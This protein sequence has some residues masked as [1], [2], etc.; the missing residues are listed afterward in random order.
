MYFL[1]STLPFYY[2]TN[3]TIFHATCIEF[4][5]WIYI[6]VRLGSTFWQILGV[7]YEHYNIFD[8]GR[9]WVTENIFYF[10]TIHVYTPCKD[11]H[12]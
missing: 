3:G 7:D 6:S 2:L 12:T 8:V 11:F 1:D 4:K 10:N 9:V 5:E